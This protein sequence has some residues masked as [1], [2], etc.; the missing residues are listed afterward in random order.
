MGGVLERVIDTLVHTEAAS[1]HVLAAGFR[2]RRTRSRYER[3]IDR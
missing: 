3:S 1:K 2:R